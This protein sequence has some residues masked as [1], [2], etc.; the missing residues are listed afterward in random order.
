MVN[1][2]F[3]L[4]RRVARN[5][6]AASAAEFALVL[7]LLLLFIF[8]II[9]VGRLMWEWNRAEKATQMGVRFAAV[10][11]IVPSG[12]AG[13][14]F[15]TQANVAQGYSVSSALFPGVRCTGTATTANCTCKGTC[16]FPL[17]SNATAFNNI[18]TRMRRMEGRITPAN[19]VIDYDYS[20]LG[21]AGNPYGPD[22]APIITVRIR[23]M[24]F[25]SIVGQLFGGVIDKEGFASSLTLEDGTG[26]VSN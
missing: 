2:V 15:A 3:H 13:Y 1:R 17:T 12:L 11:D 24:E 20:G 23:D 5:Q 22:V 25:E 14:D 16:G 9:D 10:T 7:P 4:C 6:T 18:V 26:S 21:F 19:V 8:G